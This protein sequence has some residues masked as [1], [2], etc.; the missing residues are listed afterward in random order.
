MGPETARSL[1]LIRPDPALLRLVGIVGGRAGWRVVV[2]S[3]PAEAQAVLG[4]DPAIAAILL[5]GWRSGDG[6]V[7]DILASKPAIPLLLA[8]PEG[9]SVAAMRAGATDFLATPVAPDRLLA[10]L[11]AA[12]D[13][14]RPKGELRPII[15]KSSKPLSFDE[16][17]G[18]TPAFR[19]ALAVAAKAARSRASVLIEGE[20]G[21]GKEMLARAIHAAGPRAQK[22]MVGVDCSAIPASLA[23]SFLFG[24]EKGAFAGAFERQAGRLEKADGGT[25]FI[26]DVGRLPLP[27]Q[28]RLLHVIETGEVQ[29]IG[30]VGFKTADIRIIA[31]SSTPLLEMVGEGLFREDLYYR[32][33]AVHVPIPP[34]RE[35]LGDIPALARHLLAR[36]AELPGMRPLSVTDDALSLLMSYGWPGNVRQLQNAIFRA[37]LQCEGNALTAEDLPQVAQEAAFSSR[38]D[39]YAVGSLTGASASAALAHAPGITLYGADGNLRTLEDIERDVIRLAIGHYHG[40]MTEVARRLGI[41]RSTL[42]RKLAELGISDAA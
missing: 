15:E 13:R 18:S 32:L 33:A 8:G 38:A 14:R 22:P 30:G 35:R 2:A 41:G 39:D 16:I 36:I 25:L 4:G 40:R 1:L 37:A 26:E 11:T 42:Y 29:R 10:A 20:R 21:S 23:E 28:A 24:H 9:D 5:C 6:S 12:G 19:A 3:E 31:G 27:V 7:A 34:L 17:V